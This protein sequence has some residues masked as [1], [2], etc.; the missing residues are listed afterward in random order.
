MDFFVE[1]ASGVITDLLKKVQN[2]FG[3]GGVADNALVIKGDDDQF[4]GLSPVAD[5]VVGVQA[6]RFAMIDVPG[7]RLHQETVTI[8][9]GQIAAGGTLTLVAAKGSDL[10]I[11]PVELIVE[12]VP[13]TIPPSYSSGIVSIGID[14]IQPSAQL[15]GGHQ[16]I[17][18]YATAGRLVNFQRPDADPSQPN[19]FA[20]QPITL[21]LSPCPDGQIATYA[22]TGGT[23]FAH[24]DT[25]E[26]PGPEGDNPIGVVDTVDGD[27][28]VLT[29]HLT[30]VGAA[31]G[32]TVDSDHPLASTSGSGVEGLVHVITITPNDYAVKVT[33]LFYLYRVGEG[34]I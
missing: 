14:G 1:F 22:F 23:G 20:N 11:V 27:G 4:H 30:H 25:F 19:A 33:T 5:K 15:L 8:S 13:G 21:D 32:F 28:A 18:A 2:V 24:G 6:G 17:L 9:A 10:L 12:Q 34:C 7:P 26:I 29:S 3:R 31:G 16:L